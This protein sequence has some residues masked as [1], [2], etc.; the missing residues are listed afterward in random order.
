[1]T[2]AAK[3][4]RDVWA[5]GAEEAREF[6]FAAHVA[7]IAHGRYVLRRI[8]Q[9]LDE[10]AVN[11]GLQPLQHQALLQVYGSP[12]PPSVS[13]VAERL[14][15]APALASRLVRHLE[16]HG[17]VERVRSTQDKRV[18]AVCA[19]EAGIEL[20]RRVD[21][22]VHEHVYQFHRELS[23]ESRLGALA[24][25]ASYLG[26]DSD[27]RLRALLADADIDALAHSHR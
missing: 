3:P 23:D 12:Q 18:I 10:Q 16:E 5:R 24:T 19:T 7:A 6:D 15:I 26:L 2:D 27:P 13:M 20:L 4:A 17:L 1:M 11:G 21:L 8:V 9:L 25:F 14:S 22:E